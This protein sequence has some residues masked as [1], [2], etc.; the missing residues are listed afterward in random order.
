MQRAMASEA[1]AAREARA[2]VIAAEGEEKASRS[3][4]DAAK[5]LTES[6]VAV[7]LR[8]LQ[9]LTDISVENSSTIIFP[10][11]IDMSPQISFAKSNNNHNPITRPSG[12][13]NNSSY[14]KSHNPNQNKQRAS[15]ESI[16]LMSFGN[17]IEEKSA[18]IKD[19][20]VQR[21]LEDLEKL[22]NFE[23]GNNNFNQTKNKANFQANTQTYSKTK[24]T[25]NNSNNSINSS[26]KQK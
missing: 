26:K 15:N 9:T 22:N 17:N 12:V 7:Q 10:V 25:I 14:S 5:I 11:P 24:S 3:L 20:E 8:Y 2:K 19:K 16:N 4:R 13:L 18:L 23:Q 1:E 21:A 6:P